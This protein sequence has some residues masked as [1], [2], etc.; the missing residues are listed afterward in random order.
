MAAVQDCERSVK[1]RIGWQSGN[2]KTQENKKQKKH[3][4]IVERRLVGIES[5]SIKR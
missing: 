3:A 1:G 2:R 4:C 5:A